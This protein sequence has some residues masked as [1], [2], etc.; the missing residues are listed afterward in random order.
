MLPVASANALNQSTALG[1]NATTDVTGG[2]GL[3][4]TSAT[5]AN[6]Q[7]ATTTYDALGRTLSTTRA[8]RNDRADDHHDHLQ[9]LV[10]LPAD[11]RG[12]ALCR[13][14]QQPAA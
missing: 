9:G 5:D 12:D 2:F 7:V 4:P 3:W 13:G 8:R 6:G 11:G 14:G 1:F 10:S